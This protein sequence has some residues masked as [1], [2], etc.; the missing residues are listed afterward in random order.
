MQRCNAGTLAP[1]DVG[2]RIFGVAIKQPLAM[3]LVPSASIALRQLVA[4]ALAAIG[5]A[6][7]GL[8]LACEGSPHGAW[9][10]RLRSSRSR[11]PSSPSTMRASS[12]ACARSTAATTAWSTTAWRAAMLRQ[13]LA[14][15]IAGA[16]EGGEKVFYFTPGPALPAR[17][18]APHLRRDLSRLS[19]A[20]SAVAVPGLRHV[21]AFP[22]APLGAGARARLRRRSRRRAVRLEPGAI[23]QMGGAR[24]CRSG[25]R[26][27][28]SGRLRAAGG[29]QPRRA[30]PIVSLAAVGTGAAVRA[31]AVRAARTSRRRRGFCSRAPGLA[32]LWQRPVPPCR[33]SVHRL[34]A[35]ARHGAAQ[36]DLWRRA[37]C[38]SPRPPPIPRC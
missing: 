20:H 36:L 4:P 37:L 2:R 11:S 18:R 33:R 26:H 13:L 27:L 24:L 7:V 30:A 34:P 32:A 5:A 9:C 3:R 8:W 23:R 17:R 38:F 29:A 21:P 28:L 16:L 12:A 15:D 35:G 25:R 1:E 10:C 19:L 6:V 31:R 14:G 22:A